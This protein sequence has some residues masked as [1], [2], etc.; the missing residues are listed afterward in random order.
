MI[1]NGQAT[2]PNLA[3][4]D[5]HGEIKA[6]GTDVSADQLLGDIE[7]LMILDTSAWAQLGPMGEVDARHD[8][9]RSWWWTTMSA[10]TNWKP[11]RSRTPPRK[12][13]AVW[14]WMPPGMLGVPLT[15]EIATP[16]FAAI[17]TDTGWFRFR[18]AN[19]KTYRAAAELM[20]AG[21]G[22]TRSL[23]RCTNR[24]RWAGCDCEA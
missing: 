6:L 5:P 14:C 10:K 4:I 19:P 12:P 17:A 15:P 20:E 7:V 1:V 23:R 24:T 18:S 9:L 8:R 22:P 3:F 2:P 11:S 21:P 16:L 13:R